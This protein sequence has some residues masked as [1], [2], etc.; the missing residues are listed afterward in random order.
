[1][2]R[3][4]NDGGLVLIKGWSVDFLGPDVPT[5]ALFDTVKL[6]RPQLVGLSVRTK[7]GI[8]Y[9]RELVEELSTLADT[10]RFF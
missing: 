2:H 1:M 6:R 8:E 10:R 7:Q 3:R 9:A 5:P 4:A